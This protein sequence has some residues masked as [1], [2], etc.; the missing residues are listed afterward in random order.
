M[1]LTVGLLWLLA[2]ATAV[3]WV[4]REAGEVLDSA[5]QETAERLLMLPED[6]L[7]VTD[8]AERLARVGEHKE[9]VLY[10]VFRHGRLRWRSHAAPTTALAPQAAAGLSSL[11]G[12]RLYTLERG[13]TR[14]Q[15][16][17]PQTHR[18]RLLS[19]SVL[20]L[21][22][23]L[24]PLLMLT[25][26]SVD[27]LLRRVFS[28]LEPLREQL[29]SH[30]LTDLAPLDAN[31]APSELR[32]WVEAVNTLLTRVHRL[33]D[34]ERAFAAHAAH[35]LRTPIAAAQATLQRLHAECAQASAHESLA[36]AQR[37][38]SHM[39][40]LCTRL[41]QLARVQA[42]VSLKK[43]ATELHLLVGL[44]LQEFGGADARRL[45]PPSADANANDCWVLAD[46][47]SLAIALRNLVGN[48]LQHGGPTIRVTVSP[49]CVMVCDDGAGVPRERLAD[50]AQPWQH[51]GSRRPLLGSGLG[52]ALVQ[53]IA[54]DCGGRL[55]LRSPT[56][57]GHGFCA[58]L[59]LP[60]Y[61][62]AI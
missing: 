35:E 11:A 31:A 50:L 58:A 37:Q 56:T 8:T 49:G 6:A 60:V 33:L 17:E 52:L 46:P 21:T 39:A 43:Q 3:G 5:L 4:V 57:D 53:R 55:E 54:L 34:A 42:G 59:H 44:V 47:D 45:R 2:G 26:F 23:M 51:G 24:L 7:D 15:V 25:A 38:L 61:G 18:A 14:V 28:G 1:L 48:A 16:A 29:L 41:L 40:R 10:Q 9:H 27:R 12:Y 22:L 36:A 13:D 20:G 62:A 19:G 32:P 30:A